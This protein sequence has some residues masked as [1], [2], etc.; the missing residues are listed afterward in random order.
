M[1]ISIKR[2]KKPQKPA[3]GVSFGWESGTER[4]PKA[5]KTRL[6]T[7]WALALLLMVSFGGVVLSL[8]SVSC[9]VPVLLIWCALCLGIAF[10]SYNKPRLRRG[11]SLAAVLLTTAALLLGG[12]LFR[13]GLAV[14][15]NGLKDLWGTAFRLIYLRTAVSGLYGE[16]LAVTV[17]LLP[18]I[19]VM[20]VLTAHTVLNRGRLMLF[21]ALL[22][23]FVLLI[24]AVVSPSWIWYSLLSLALFLLFMAGISGIA[25]GKSG[26]GALLFSGGIAAVIVMALCLLPLTGVFT[27]GYDKPEICSAV[28]E[29]LISFGEDLRWRDDQTNNLPQG[30][31]NQ[32]AP[33]ERKDEPALEVTMSAPCSLYLRGYVGSVY[34]SEGWEPVDRAALYAYADTF[35]WLHNNG[36][37]GMSQLS[38]AAD[39]AGKEREEIAVT[40][41]N[42]HAGNRYIYSPYEYADG[43][44]GK[45]ASR[46][47]DEAPCPAD[48]DDFENV[49]YTIISNQ[50]KTAGELG[51]SLKEQAAAGNEETLFYLENEGAYRSFVY[52]T[53]LTIPEDTLSV[54]KTHLGEADLS[55][56]HADYNSAMQA[57]LNELLTNVTYNEDVSAPKDGTDFCRNFLENSG[58]G[59]SVHYATAA[60]LMFRYYGIPSRYV[61]GYIIT[62]ADAAG[63]GEGEPITVTGE[64]AHAWVEYYRDGVGWIPFEVTPPYLF[65]MERP[66]QMKEQISDTLDSQSNQQGMVQM[67]QDNYEDIE[68]DED[69]SDPGK[70]GFSPVWIA[71]FAGVFIFL[72][73]AAFFVLW[74]R[75]RKVMQKRRRELA[76]A[77]DRQA[78]NLLFCDT[79]NLL[80]AGGLKRKNGSLE[81]M[82]SELEELG[83]EGLSLRYG[84]AVRLHR[85]AVFS[86]HSVSPLRRHVFALLRE[87]AKTFAK[88]HSRYVKRWV[89]RYIRHLY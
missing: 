2:I 4:N 44:T 73:L 42:L 59:Y 86:D 30:R 31:L 49:T 57:I 24:P 64:N 38:S 55:S 74:L 14:I 84:M 26:G 1:M 75:R 29:Q 72:L 27:N 36:F 78:V 56:G 16:S 13:D 5:E 40:V 47:G 61:E 58:E 70:S 66:D 60:A 22:F 87:E 7:L 62:P 9:N 50:V 19:M 68:E 10:F 65:V 76:E 46:I 32:T 63:A 88:K 18:V 3:G 53:Y 28:E 6:W 15:L 83:G 11:I 82:E 41:R 43:A 85:E 77:D 67:E 23:L 71:V 33:L 34:T 54:L 69:Q 89:D 52:D 37:Y 35:Y 17:F 45:A 81:D 80:G 20:S 12:A 39:A 25:A 8:L 48:Y 79:L 21:L 51:Q